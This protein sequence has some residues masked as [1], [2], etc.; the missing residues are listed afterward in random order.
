VQDR[1][2]IAP[3][4]WVTSDRVVG[5]SVD[6]VDLTLLRA[7]AEDS[8]LS[9][10]ALARQVGMSA[11]AVGERIARLERTGVIRGYRT[12]IDWSALG[13]GLVAYLSIVCVQGQDQEQVVSGLRALD[14]VEDVQVVTGPMDLIVRVRVRD[15]GQLRTSLFDRI[16]KIPG[17]QRSETLISLA[18]MA[19]KNVALGFI[20]VLSGGVGAHPA[21]GAPGEEV[22]APDAGLGVAGPRPL[23]A[24]S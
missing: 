24:E 13:L 22:T 8:R 7:L 21:A 11:P 2:E 20:D 17:V 16:W 18:G 9:Q 6:D 19:P 3:P 10:R 5:A 23:R 15:H 1:P 12:E 14:E 4:G